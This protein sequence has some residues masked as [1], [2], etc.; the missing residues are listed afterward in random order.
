M[1]NIRFKQAAITNVDCA[2]KLEACNTLVQFSFTLNLQIVCGKDDYEYLV[3][4]LPP[5]TRLLNFC[6]IFILWNSYSHD[7]YT[8]S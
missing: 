8:T 2:I 1:T 3:F 7:V 5:L 6:K 4:H